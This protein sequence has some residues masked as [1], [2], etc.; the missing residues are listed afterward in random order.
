MAIGKRRA[1]ARFFRITTEDT[2]DTEG[3]RGAR[4]CVCRASPGPTFPFS[5]ERWPWRPSAPWQQSRSLQRW[6]R[7]SRRQRLLRTSASPAKRR[8][9]GRHRKSD[10]DQCRISRIQVRFVEKELACNWWAENSLVHRSA[11][12]ERNVEADTGPKDHRRTHQTPST[13]AFQFI[14]TEILDM[15]GVDTH[16]LGLRD[17]KSCLLGNG[18]GVALLRAKLLLEGGVL[19]DGFEKLGEIFLGHGSLDGGMVGIV[20]KTGLAGGGIRRSRKGA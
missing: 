15:V 13:D 4:F 12:H 1:T 8:F 5:S 2:G 16:E 10:G 7:P 9:R 14:V 18:Q 19:A 11:L 6:Q 17:G 3:G 20:R